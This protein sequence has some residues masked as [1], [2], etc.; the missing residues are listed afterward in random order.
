MSKYMTGSGTFTHESIGRIKYTVRS[1]ARRLVAR[2]HADM[3]HLTLPPYMTA[4]E[5]L[6]AIS[7][8]EDRILSRKPTNSPYSF[9]QIFDFKDFVVRITGRE[10]FGNRC[11]T[12]RAGETGFEIR[13]DSKLDIISPEVMK[14]V[15]NAMRGIARHMAP[16]LL[17]PRANELAA[18]TG[19]H[20]KA[21]EI[22]SGVRVLGHCNSKG[23][24]A[25]S[26]IVVFLPPHLRDY[27]IFHELAHLSE[28]NHSAAF[29]KI[30][31]EYCQGL[32]K[33][34]IKELKGFRFP[35]V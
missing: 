23:V 7:Q 28:M 34:Y 21:W 4:A 26:Y 32:E 13:L 14:T 3:L 6:Q 29:H 10:G 30:C 15:S 33:Q 16:K 31:N 2:W 11:A 12:Y 20:P 35:I 1:T 22:S 8:M 18:I 27:I 17:L 5:M 25:L 24:I 9:D 19:K